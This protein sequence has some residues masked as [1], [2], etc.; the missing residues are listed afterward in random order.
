MRAVMV[1]FRH[2]PWFSN[3]RLSLHKDA[4]YHL[5][6]QPNHVGRGGRVCQGG[7]RHDRLNGGDDLEEFQ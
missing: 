1:T 7:L 5:Q 4:H 6:T 3:E 2:P